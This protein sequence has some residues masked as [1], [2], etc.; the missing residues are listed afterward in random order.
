LLFMKL[1]WCEPR[2]YTTRNEDDNIPKKIK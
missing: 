1:S 2:D